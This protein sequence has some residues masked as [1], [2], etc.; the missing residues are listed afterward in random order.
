MLS[1]VSGSLSSAHGRYLSYDLVLKGDKSLLL[2]ETP[3]LKNEKSLV[4][5]CCVV[6]L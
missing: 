2:L 4:L 1:I 3:V 5:F 6:M